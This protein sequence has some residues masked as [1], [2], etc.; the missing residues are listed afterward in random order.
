MAHRTVTVLG[1]TGFLGRR[2]VSNLRGHGFAVRVASRHPERGGATAGGDEA[3]IESVYA[4]VNDETSI[5]AALA[6][7]FGAVNAVSLY[8]ERGR[9]TFQSVHVEAAA[10]VARQARQLG[11][12]R[13][14]HVSGIGSDPESTSPYI[15]S[16]GRGEIAVRTDFPTATLVRPAVMFGPGDA[17]LVPI[18]GMLRRLPVFAMFGHGRTKL[19]PAYVDDVAEG[20]SRALERPTHDLAYE[21]AGPHVY[22]YASLLRIVARQAEAKVLLVP[23]PFALWQASALLA[24]HLPSPPITRNQVELMRVDNVASADAPGFATLGITPRS[25]EEVLPRIVGTA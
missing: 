17:F 7:S 1:G 20:I 24:E 2:V 14:A 6:G 4:D 10:R 5:A 9:Q 15:R 3:Q 13:L 25:L 18:A 21:F 11:I 23:M 12:E 8:V 19:Q 16:R 22:S